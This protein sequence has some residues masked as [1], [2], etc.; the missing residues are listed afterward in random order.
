M[1]ISKEEAE[2]SLE[3]I[4]AVA[5]HT[6]KTIA[7]SYD[8]SLLIMWGL[9]WI[10]GFL[11][12]HFFLAWVWPIWMS[13]CG[14]G[15][16]ATLGFSWRQFRSANPV[17]IPA[18]EKVGWR[19]FLFWSSLFV[20]MFIW[21]SILKPRHGI[22]LNA[23]MITTIMFAYVVTGLWFKCYYM[24]WLGIAVTFTTLVGFYL[25]PTGYYCL[26][27]ALTGG[28][29]LFGTGLYMRLFWK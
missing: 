5:T 27:M 24:L 22:Q 17:K 12:T 16:I 11:G 29:A 15:M 13:L 3:Q 18:A 28:G 9:I 20:Y 8:S 2:S 1:D 19:I 4:Q 10:L 25:I 23:F 26:W 7:A 14:T 21:L 6:R